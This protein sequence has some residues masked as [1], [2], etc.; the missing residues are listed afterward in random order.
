MRAQ[1]SNHATLQRKLLGKTFEPFTTLSPPFRELSPAVFCIMRPRACFKY[2]L[3][4]DPHIEV[5]VMFEA[6]NDKE[7]RISSHPPN[8]CLVS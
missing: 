1:R 5:E 8:Q 7:A 3:L 6:P 4:D 2:G